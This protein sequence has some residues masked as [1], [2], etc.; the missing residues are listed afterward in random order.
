MQGIAQ[1][2]Q[3]TARHL[4]MKTHSAMKA[5][6]ATAVN[7]AS[8]GLMEVNHANVDH[9]TATA[10][11]AVTVASAVSA[12]MAKALATTSLQT[13]PTTPLW[14]LK[15]VC[16]LPIVKPHQPMLQPRSMHQHP[17]HQ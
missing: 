10:A 8:A 6:T 17:K 13:K 5:K 1:H 9:V 2:K 4:V 11:T 16:P 3:A 15:T 14:R 7:R 12:A